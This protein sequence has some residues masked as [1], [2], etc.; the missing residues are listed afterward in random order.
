MHWSSQEGLLRLV[1]SLFCSLLVFATVPLSAHQRQTDN[2]NHPSLLVQSEAMRQL[3]ATGA[4]VIPSLLK[5]IETEP[6]HKTWRHLRILAKLKVKSIRPKLRRELRRRISDPQLD[7]IARNSAIEALSWIAAPDDVKLILEKSIAL[8][9]V[10]LIPFISLTQIASENLSLFLKGIYLADPSLTTYESTISRVIDALSMQPSQV[11]KLWNTGDT[12]EKVGALFII[13]HIG[14]KGT[15]HIFLSGLQSHSESILVQS[16]KGLAKNVNQQV[17]SD[18][19]ALMRR[20]SSHPVRY[21]ALSL[22]IQHFNLLSVRQ[23][24]DLSHWLPS[25]LST[26]HIS[27]RLAAITLASKL[28]LKSSYNAIV[29]L[30]SADTPSPV[31]SAILEYLIAVKPT[32][33]KTIISDFLKNLPNADHNFS[34]DIIEKATRLQEK[35]FLP[36]IAQYMNDTQLHPNIRNGLIKSF[37]KLTPSI[38]KEKTAKQLLPLLDNSDLRLTTLK[39]L[40]KLRPHFLETLLISYLR[41]K[42]IAIKRYVVEALGKIKSRKALKY[43]IA[44]I[45]QNDPSLTV[46]IVNALAE[47]GDR[48]ALNPITLIL[49]KTD[50]SDITLACLNALKG[51]GDSSTPPYLEP[52]LKSKNRD[53]RRKAAEV[54]NQLKNRPS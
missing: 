52:F 53:I 38:I 5:S 29:H 44:S 41:D 27:L 20:L 8:P 30:L 51:M 16:L 25:V 10:G 6:A 11:L 15:Q 4:S 39:M 37:V 50:H 9:Q 45:R 14:E 46:S 2:L 12:A 26:P 36:L 43:L 31:T 47:I 21:E 42:H 1:R 40:V 49:L 24:R 34:L 32:V 18:V 48:K 3:E 54:Y 35:A 13:R 33:A 7:L 19:L 22:L 17:I 28:K 23:K